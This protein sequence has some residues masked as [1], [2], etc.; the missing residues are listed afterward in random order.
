VTSTVKVEK[1]IAIPSNRLR[2]QKHFPWLDMS[3]GDSFTVV[4]KSAVA[5]ARGSFRRYQKLFL[6]AQ[7]RIVVQRRVENTPDTYR[8]WLELRKGN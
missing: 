8:L 5:S 6:I 7:D 2:S 3:I 4:G 1:N